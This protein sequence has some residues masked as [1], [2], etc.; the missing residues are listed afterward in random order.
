MVRPQLGI[1]PVVSKVGK[2]TG[3]DAGIGHR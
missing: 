2:E 3:N 1:H